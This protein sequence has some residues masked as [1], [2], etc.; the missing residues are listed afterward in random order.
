MSNLTGTI[1]LTIVVLFGSIEQSHGIQ[2]RIVE[3]YLINQLDDERGFC[4]DIKG[5]KTRAKIVRGLQ[6]HTCYS[7][8]G[9]ISID[10]GFDAAELTRNKFFLPAFDV[11][12]EAVSSGG[13]TNLR[14]NPCR[15]EKLQEFK[16]DK[17]GTITTAGNKDLCLTVAGG[18][19]RK[20][21]GG[22]PLHL[23]RNLSLQPCDASLRYL[24]RWAVR[25]AN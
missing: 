15:E 13:P 9:S 20:G 10:Q 21:G 17:S 18:K 16:F 4:L 25:D 19:S 11:C 7:Y 22:S 24:Q 23:M 5:H 1:C 6:A 3:V 12:M 14:L 2:Q 8:Q